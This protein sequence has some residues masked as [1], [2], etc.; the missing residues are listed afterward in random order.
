MKIENTNYVNYLIELSQ[1]ERKSAFFDLCEINLSSV[2][3]IIYRLTADYDLSR[4]L[5]VTT[6]LKAWEKIKNYD[7]K[8]PFV[9]W[10][11]NIA[12]NLALENLNRIAGSSQEINLTEDRL[13][14]LENLIMNLDYERRIIFVLHDLEGYSYEEVA[15]FLNYDFVDEIKIKLIETRKYLIN[16]IC[17]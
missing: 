11:K 17:K 3:T 12:I 2:F 16:K 4:K 1:N 10:I 14:N 9:L 13:K 15:N 8:I 7:Y 5:T 6:F